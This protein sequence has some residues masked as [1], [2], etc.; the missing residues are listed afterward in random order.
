MKFVVDE[1]LPPLLATRLTQWGH[2]SI[3]VF[4]TPE[5]RSSGDPAIRTFADATGRAVI[6]KDRDH[7]Q[8]RRDRGTP[9]A[10]LF[11]STRNM[12]NN[13]F[14]TLFQAHWAELLARLTADGFADLG[15][16]GVVEPTAPTVAA[17]APDPPVGADDD[18]APD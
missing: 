14:L 18:A 8:S 15:P 10:L 3:H 6:S 9:Q 5:G 4:D 13:Q 2:E 7:L 16:D 1:Q 17:T 12:S 11:V